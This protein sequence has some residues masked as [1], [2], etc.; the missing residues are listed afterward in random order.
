MVLNGSQKIGFWIYMVSKHYSER[1][2]TF[3][4]KAPLKKIHW[5]IWYKPRNDLDEKKP[6]P[7]LK[8]SELQYFGHLVT[9]FPILHLKFVHEH[10]YLRPGINGVPI[11]CLHLP[12]SSS[13][14]LI[15]LNNGSWA[16]LW[17]FFTSRMWVASLL[18]YRIQNRFSSSK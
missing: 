9:L 12:N 4:N 14:F 10:I 8:A 18:K 6:Y 13:D 3:I 16:K 11:D 2:L 7:S 1:K 15:W 5:L 17:H